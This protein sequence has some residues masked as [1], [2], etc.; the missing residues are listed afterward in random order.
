MSTHPIYP[1]RACAPK[2]AGWLLATL[3]VSAVASA[4]PVPTSVSPSQAEVLAAPFVL[5]VQGTGFTPNTVVVWE[6]SGV[7]CV[8]LATTYVSPTQ[9]LATVPSSVLN[10]LAAATGVQIGVFAPSLS[11]PN[12]GPFFQVNVP[13]A[14]VSNLSPSSAVAGSGPISLVVTG[15]TFLSGSVVRW[16]GQALATT[17]NSPTQATAMVPASLLQTA[18][19]ASVGVD[20][21]PN[22]NYG[23]SS[24][25]VAATF[26]ITEPFA[27]S[28]ACQPIPG[29]AQL[30]VSI[31]GGGAGNTYQMFVAIANPNVAPQGPFFGIDLTYQELGQQLGL[32]P[33]SGLLDASGEASAAIPLPGYACPISL[34]VDIVT[35]EFDASAGTIA[36]IDTARTLNL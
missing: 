19:S 13:G 30:D 23:N 4:Q 35:L 22:S 3:L 10:P 17:V 2:L 26:T 14:V 28:I 25:P 33:L 1:P 32:A 15:T 11:S 29:G 7:S 9:L 34:T 20:N 16:D 5:T 6:Y 21:D 31:V 27:G 12:F 24:T 18:G 8:T 36:Q